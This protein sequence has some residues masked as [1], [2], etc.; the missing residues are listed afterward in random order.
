MAIGTDGY[1]IVIHSYISQNNDVIL[2]VSDETNNTP[3]Y[4][5]FVYF[6]LKTC[7]IC[8]VLPIRKAYR[9]GCNIWTLFYKP[10][11]TTN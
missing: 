5:Y 2:L 6:E 1:C 4:I 8:F 7:S 11:I 3:R 9:L 10:A